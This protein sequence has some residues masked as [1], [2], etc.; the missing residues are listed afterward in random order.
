MKKKI[1]AAIC[2][3]SLVCVA[4]I[5]YK[6][7]KSNSTSYEEKIRIAN[8]EALSEN[9]SSAT[10][11]IRRDYNCEYI[12]YGKANS[13]I[14]IYLAGV[15]IGS[16]TAGADGKAIYVYGSGKTDCS[17]GGNQMCEQRYCPQLSFM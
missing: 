16:V 17:G 15:K 11:Y 6:C 2:S 3:L 13:Q 9:E 14:D 1:F 8:L 7:I 4:F 12:F 5:G 10:S